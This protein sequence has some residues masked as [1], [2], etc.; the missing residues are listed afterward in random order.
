MSVCRLY[1]ASLYSSTEAEYLEATPV[2]QIDGA[3]VMVMMM[4]MLLTFHTT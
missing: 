1:V 3:S 2:H 4:V